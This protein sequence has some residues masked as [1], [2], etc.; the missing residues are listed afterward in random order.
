MSKELVVFIDC[1]DTIVD[2]ST[3]L[4]AENGD[5]LSA[6]AFPGAEQMLR[7]LRAQGYRIAL[8]ADGRTASFTNILLRLGLNDLFEAKVISEEVGAVKPAASMFET[9][10]AAMGLTKN[11]ASRIAMIGNNLKR[12]IVGANRM[13][14]ISILMSTSPRYVMQPETPE[15]VPDYVVALPCEVVGLLEQL[16]LQIRNRRVLQE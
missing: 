5:V 1:G 16:E 6:E 13:G 3:Q 9:A 15:E 2:E 4:F 10:L 14:I 12:D 8:V 11:D 7:D